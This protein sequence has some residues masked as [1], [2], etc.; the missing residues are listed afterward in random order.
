MNELFIFITEQLK[1]DWKYLIDNIGYL[2]IFWYPFIILFKVSLFTSPI[3]LPF[4][5][6]LNSLSSAKGKKK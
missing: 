3:W 6:I 5:F 2:S 1:S 4:S